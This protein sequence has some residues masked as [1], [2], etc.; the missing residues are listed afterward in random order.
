M[1][2]LMTTQEVAD[3]LRIKKQTLEAWRSKN[4]NNIPCIK[5]GTSVRYRR[6]DVEEWVQKQ[7]NKGSL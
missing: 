3:Y 5:I 6:R 1:E 7:L 4:I 2:E